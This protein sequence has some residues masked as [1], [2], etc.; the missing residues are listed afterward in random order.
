MSSGSGE[1]GTEGC[2]AVDAED[3]L[4]AMLDCLVG[5]WVITMVVKLQINIVLTEVLAPRYPPPYPA[6]VSLLSFEDAT[7][8]YTKRVGRLYWPP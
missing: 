8:I 6:N 3:G 7:L 4:R 2:D 1:G 5:Y